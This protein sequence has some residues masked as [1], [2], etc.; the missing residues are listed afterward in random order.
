CSRA[1]MPQMRVL[2]VVVS[3]EIFECIFHRMN[4]LYVL[5]GPRI[6]K[7]KPRIAKQFGLL[8]CEK[9]NP[10]FGILEQFGQSLNVLM[11]NFR[12]IRTPSATFAEDFCSLCAYF[13]MLVFADLHENRLNAQ[14]GFSIG[15][16]SYLF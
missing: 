12:R 2:V 5:D 15:P 9:S 6:W 11:W 8:S 10:W 14:I 13:G 3:D 16:T 1:S 4:A 7:R